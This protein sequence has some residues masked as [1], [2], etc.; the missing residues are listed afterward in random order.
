M[1]QICLVQLNTLSKS[2]L[3]CSIKRLGLLKGVLVFCN[4]AKEMR[5]EDG[6]VT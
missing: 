3:Q 4:P 2:S 6:Q 5:F 1:A